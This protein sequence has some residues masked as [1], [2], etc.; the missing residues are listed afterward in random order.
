M[1]KIT[2]FIPYPEVGTTIQELIGDLDDEHWELEIIQANYASQIA[3]WQNVDTDVIISRGITAIAARERYPDIPVVDIQ[4]TGYDMMRAVRESQQRFPGARMAIVGSA[5]MTYGAKI[6]EELMAV[7][8]EVVAVVNETDATPTIARLKEN[9]VDVII[10]GVMP[11]LIAERCG[12]DAVF[13]RTGREAIYHALREA[14]RA[15]QIRRKEQERSEQFRTI[16]DYSVEGI[17]AVDAAGKVSLVNA[18]AMKHGRLQENAVGR[19]GDTLLPQ[20]V[21]GKTLATGTARLGEIETL[22]GHAMAVNT[23]PIKVNHKTVGAV[24]TFRPVADIQEQEGKLRRKIYQRGL[25]AKH[26]FS[27]IV[28]DSRAVRRAIETASEF[29]ELD[30][31]VLITGETGTGKEIFAQSIHNA[32]PRSHG[33]FVAINCAALPENLLESELFGYV[34]GAFSGASRSGKIGLFELAHRGTIFLDEISEISP[35]LQGHLLRVLQERE[36]MRLGDDRVIPVDV[37][38]IAATNRNLQ[39]MMRDERFREDLYYRLDILRLTL[40]PLRERRDDIIPLMRGFLDKYCRQFKRSPKTL[41]ADAEVQLRSY[42]WPGNVRELRNIAERLAA[43]R[44][45]ETIGAREIKEVLQPSHDKPL[46]QTTPTSIAETPLALLRGRPLDQAT[47]LKAVEQ[48]GF[49][50]GRAAASLGISRTTLWR[51]MREMA[52]AE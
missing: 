35:K 26:V 24:A 31:N 32:G 29:S 20:M 42:D 11:T 1:G 3:Q 15:V 7:S 33:P 36:I 52:N 25:V 27:D 8:V 49:H 9:G 4:V 45:G 12:I 5:N 48:S 50:Y 10:G 14:I 46:T 41:G 23:I 21:F 51:R 22:G 2:C 44:Q 18:A 43:L 17:V 13:I 28:G 6:I 40:P 30:S 19:P 47:L 34:E 38:I 37:R 39:K 16:L